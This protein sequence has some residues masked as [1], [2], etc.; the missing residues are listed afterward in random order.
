L[1]DRSL[2]AFG[3]VDN[4]RLKRVAK[5]VLRFRAD[6]VECSCLDPCVND[7]VLPEAE[8]IF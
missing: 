2:P 3:L 6:F 5:E 8:Q 7:R 1:F 4:A